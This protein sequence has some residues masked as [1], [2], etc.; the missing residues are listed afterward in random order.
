[1]SKVKKILVDKGA[2]IPFYN[3]MDFCVGSGRMGLALHK[4]YY[5]QLKMV[6]EAIGFK[7]IRGHGLFCA[8][9]SLIQTY[10]DESGSQAVE[11]NFT[12][13]DR[14]I[15]SY[16]DLGIRPF[17]ELGF[18]PEHMASGEQTVFYWKANVTPPKD[19][20]DW[21]DMVQAALRH[22]ID[23]YGRENVIQWPIEVWNEPNQ[24]DF[25]KDADMDEY[26]RLY[27]HTALA[28]K[29]TDPGFI[30]GGPSI[31]GRLD[32]ACMRS[33]L[34]YVS[35][36]KLPLD[37]ISRHNYIS[38][39]PEKDGRYNYV[40][41]S[42]IDDW[43]QPLDKTRELVDSFE[44][45]RGMDIHVT[46]YN[47]SYVPDCPLHDTNLN[48]A[49]TA[50]LLSRFGDKHASYAYWTF[51]DIFEERGVPYTPFYGGFGMVANNCIPKPT[52]WTFAF[53]KQLQ[54]RCVHRSDEAIIIRRPEGSYRGI[55]WNTDF[56]YEG[57]PLEL[58]IQLPAEFAGYCLVT[59]TVDEECCNPL[60]LWHD[61]GEPFNL[62]QAQTAL[63][64]RHSVPLIK[65]ERISCSQ[66]KIKISLM[67]KPNG[68]IYFDLSKTKMKSDRGYS[69][70]RILRGEIKGEG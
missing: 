69:Y 5:E 8:D 11:Y 44:E 7:Y 21:T 20:K 63:L 18:M 50:A 48:A 2:E 52:F 12:Y 39:P 24:P 68:V 13:L 66:S 53:Y 65:S 27:E 57:R 29:R 17:L 19:Y 33:F 49:Y 1:M 58:E 37:F 62:T 3:R 55:L 23:R 32:E 67:L 59:E 22:L 47:T 30:I 35:Y 60:K 10:K 6:Q 15:D 36:K 61:M 46:E 40:K 54:G 43:F 28:V 64:K 56:G 31:S 41:L 45:F 25:W 16:I 38:H 34:E 9:M 4:E 14:V 51:G 70:E 26:F 42:S